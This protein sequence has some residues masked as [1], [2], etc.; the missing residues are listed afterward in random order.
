M[1]AKFL[2]LAAIA[3][4]LLLQEL[5]SQNLTASGDTPMMCFR[6]IYRAARRWKFE[7]HFERK[8]EE[9]SKR[10]L[11]RVGMKREQF[12]NNSKHSMTLQME[13]AV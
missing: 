10:R 9:L 11:P 12:F 5:T 13:T 8:I 4:S 6:T 2:S 7:M 3:A 1:K